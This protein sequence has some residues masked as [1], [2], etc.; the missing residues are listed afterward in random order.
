MDLLL[1]PELMVDMFEAHVDLVIA[2]L[3]K[4]ATYGIVPDGLFMAEDMGVSTGLM[5]SLQ[6][7]ISLLQ[8]SQKRLGDYLHRNRITY[9][10]HTDG[11][12]LQLIP[13]LI[14]TG[15]EVL[16]PMEAKAG[17]DV[18]RLKAEYGRDLSFMGNI[19]ATR[20]DGDPTAVEAEIRDKLLIARVGGGYIYHSDHSVPPTVSWERYQWVVACVRKYG[21]Y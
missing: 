4:A 13:K 10:I 15:I 9:F 3:A 6:T 11:N 20:M 2:T 18:R 17:M 16:Q 5:F 1:E 14:E 19:D 8:P 21:K 7:Y 12:V